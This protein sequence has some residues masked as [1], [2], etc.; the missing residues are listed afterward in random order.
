MGH[1]LFVRG[2]N[3]LPVQDMDLGLLRVALVEGARRSKRPKVETALLSWEYQGPG[4][5]IN[6]SEKLLEGEVAVFD[7]AVEWVRGFGEAVPL[8]YLNQHATLFAAYWIVEQR[9]ERIIEKLNELKA[10][11]A[12]VA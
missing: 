10:F 2:A 5:W 7:S 8:Q 11:L 3:A 4:V 6:V 9:T 12:P 1:H